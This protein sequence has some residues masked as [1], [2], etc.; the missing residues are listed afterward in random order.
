M[1]RKSL[2]II[3]GTILIAGFA[4]CVSTK[5][6]NSLATRCKDENDRLTARVDELTT[7]VNELTALN[8]KLKNENTDLKSDTA[9]LGS[10]YRVLQGDYS[11]L[12]QSFAMLK[13]QNEGNLEETERIMA[14]L[15]SA[16]DDL[17]TRE[18][19]LKQ[20]QAELDAK[21]RSLM[22]LQAALNRNDSITKAM[23]KA[24]A[25]AL[26]GFEGK[27]LSV[28]TKNGKVYVSM[29]EKLL[30][31]SGK[32]DVSPDGVAALKN[33]AGVLEKNPD[34]TV[35]IEGHTDNVPYTGT[36]QVKDNWD[37]SVMRATAIVKILTS[38]SKINPRR[39][40]SSGRSE[41]LPV[42]PNT[43]TANK[44][45]NRRTEIILT[46]KLDELLQII[47]ND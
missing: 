27:G 24:V 11:D 47:G 39:L 36:G 34:I 17:L 46:P 20:L 2:I 28:Y 38:N 9:Q 10:A 45:K 8:Q 1:Y 25:D 35:N 12:D 15:K 44:A 21:S 32:W 14:D 26:L 33:L 4:S 31:A 29:D 19:N 7:S 5:K 18:D 43:S 23:R 13:A 16:Q 41:Y 42:E 37:L 3:V 40:I 30:F 22:E 6:Y